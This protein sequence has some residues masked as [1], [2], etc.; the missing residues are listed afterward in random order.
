LN[1][2]FVDDSMSIAWTALYLEDG[3][4]WSVLQFNLFQQYESSSSVITLFDK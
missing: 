2:I 4:T 3:P 1:K